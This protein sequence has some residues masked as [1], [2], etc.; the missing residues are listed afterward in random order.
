MSQQIERNSIVIEEWFENLNWPGKLGACLLH[1]LL[2][3][4]SERLKGIGQTVLEQLEKHVFE[5][6]GITEKRDMNVR[7]M[8]MLISE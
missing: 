3:S 2:T 4:D 1:R 7:E 6:E 5:T 8:Y